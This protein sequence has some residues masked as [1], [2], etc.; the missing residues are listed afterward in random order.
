[1]SRNVGMLSYDFIEKIRKGEIGWEVYRKEDRSTGEPVCVECN[2]IITEEED[3][4]N[5][6]ICDSCFYKKVVR[7]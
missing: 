4:T 7:K 5:G 6:C 3:I 2:E 1:M